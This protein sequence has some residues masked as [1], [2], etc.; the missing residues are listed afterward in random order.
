MKKTQGR[1]RGPLGALL[2]DHDLLEPRALAADG[3]FALRHRRRRRAR[4]Q[5]LSFKRRVLVLRFI[6]GRDVVLP[7]VREVA[8]RQRDGVCNQTLRRRS[9]R[10]GNPA[11][12]RREP[13]AAVHERDARRHERALRLILLISLRLELVVGV[14]R[15]S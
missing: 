15:H 11:A 1:G 12:A 9:Q 8:H 6:Y 14:R 7:R 3:H 10:R 5:R 2:L 13:A 4:P